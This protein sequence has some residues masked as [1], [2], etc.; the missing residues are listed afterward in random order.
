MRMRKLWK[1]FN[2]NSISCQNISGCYYCK[3][4]TWMWP[5]C[6]P[7][8][9]TV[10]NN[11]HC[12]VGFFV[13]QSRSLHQRPWAPEQISPPDAAHSQSQC[14][15]ALHHPPCI[16]VWLPQSLLWACCPGSLWSYSRASLFLSGISCDLQTTSPKSTDVSVEP[17]VLLRKYCRNRYRKVGTGTCTRRANRGRNQENFHKLS[18]GKSSQAKSCVTKKQLCPK[19]KTRKLYINTPLYTKRT[20]WLN[21][22]CLTRRVYSLNMVLQNK[23]FRNLYLKKLHSLLPETIVLL[24]DYC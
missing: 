18:G 2:F 11:Q 23:S 12:N 17:K 22:C 21:M 16:S 7:T 14:W 13:A 5:D 15:A 19:Y 20:L 8:S 9:N 6:N 4:P 24:D 3:Y 10:M 1:N